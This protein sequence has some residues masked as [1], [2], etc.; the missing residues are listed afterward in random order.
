[1]DEVGN[2]E[3]GQKRRDIVCQ[4]DQAF[5]YIRADQVQGCREDD[6]IDDIVDDTCIGQPVRVSSRRQ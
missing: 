3:L 6:D 1:M 2:D 5:G 4:Q